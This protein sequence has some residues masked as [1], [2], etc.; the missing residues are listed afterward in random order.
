[1]ALVAGKSNTVQRVA[2]HSPNVAKSKGDAHGTWTMVYDEGF[3][4]NVGGLN[5]LAFSNFTFEENPKD[6]LH[7]KQSVSHCGDT[8][9][10][11]YRDVKRTQFGCYYGKKVEQK[12]APLAQKAVKAAKPDSTKLTKKAMVKKVAKLNAKLSMLQL[13]WKARTV[14][15]FVGRT[16]HEI[17]TYAGIQRKTDVKKDMMS[18]RKQQRAKSFLQATP[19]TAELPATFDWGNASKGVDWLEPVMDQADCG[20]CY[21][22]SSMRMLSV[23]HKIKQNDQEALPWSINLP[24]HCGEY[25]Q[26]CKGGYGSLVSKWGE[27]VGLLPATCMRYDTAGTCKLECDLKKL[28]GKRYRAANHRFIGGFYGNSSANAM[29]EEIYHNGPIVVSFEPAED[30]MYYA[31]GI[32]KTAVTKTAKP[33]VLV[34]SRIANPWVKVD[35]AVLAVGW[36]VENGK[37][38]WRVQNSWGEDWGEDGFFRMARGEDESGIESIPEAAD[39]IEDEHNGQRVTEFFEQMKLKQPVA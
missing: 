30:F 23:R 20:S 17:N 12:L 28:K 25:N 36:G 15:K 19:K 5:F 39:V 35:H 34:E 33:A 26:G 38:Y 16:M 18:Q 14:A 2:L 24:L 4:V 32:Y 7:K 37:K 9:V 11:W 3:E 1:M 31:D 13:G 27:D 8:M 22:A 29:M 21:V 10:G 6:I